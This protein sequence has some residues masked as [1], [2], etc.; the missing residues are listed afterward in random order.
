MPFIDAAQAR[1]AAAL[2][3]GRAGA[4][5]LILAVHDD[6]HEGFIAVA[7][8]VFMN[9]DSPYFGYVAQDAFPGRHWLRCAMALFDRPGIR[10]VAFNDGKWFG[11]LAA[12]GLAC[13]AWA[14][15]NYGG[16]LFYPGYR[17]HYADA[18]LSVIASQAGA[19]GY[20]PHSIL[21]EL[22]WE[23]DNKQVDAADRKLFLARSGGR[24]DER[25]SSARLLHRFA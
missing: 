16:P 23:K 7:N 17:R 3:A 8:R 25:V 22:D 10:L 21:V 13:R 9:S 12:Y 24:F 18:E 1:K 11:T 4:E 2:M 19:L 15:A 14:S 5:G 20:S 6:R